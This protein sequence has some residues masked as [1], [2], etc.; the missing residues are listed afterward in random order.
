MSR[1]SLSDAEGRVT[2]AP[3]TSALRPRLLQQAQPRCICRRLAQ[4]RKQDVCAVSPVY[5]RL[6][7]LVSSLSPLPPRLPLRKFERFPN[8]RATIYTSGTATHHNTHVLYP[9]PPPP[10]PRTKPRT[11]CSQNT[12][13]VPPRRRAPTDSRP[14][15]HARSPPTRRNWPSSRRSSL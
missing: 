9:I 1:R 6:L 4:R 5:A 11:H 13:P 14:R 12:S 7:C 8:H 3:E 10:H 2:R 15:R